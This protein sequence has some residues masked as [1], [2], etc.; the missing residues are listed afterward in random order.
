MGQVKAE[1]ERLVRARGR[2]GAH[3]HQR[4]S[5]IVSN[6]GLFDQASDT[7]T[8]SRRR[9]R[10]R[11]RASA[12]ISEAEATLSQAFACLFVCAALAV[13][14]SGVFIHAV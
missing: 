4:F 10:A 3:E 14:L 11:Q 1:R 2:P 5:P 12:W 6:N 9:T 13:D 7:H 8:H